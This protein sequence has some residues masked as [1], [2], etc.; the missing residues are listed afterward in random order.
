MGQKRIA[1][2]N[3][4]YYR[5]YDIDPG[6]NLSVVCFRYGHRN[7]RQIYELDV[8]KPFRNWFP[9]P[10]IIQPHV[11]DFYIPVLGGTSSG[12]S[13]RG[14]ASSEFIIVVIRDENGDV[15]AAP[16]TLK[17]IE[18]G[19]SD[20]GTAVST[21]GD[22]NIYLTNLAAGD[23]TLASKDFMLQREADAKSPVPPV[24]VKNLPMRSSKTDTSEHIVLTRSDTNVLF[25]RRMLYIVCPMC[26]DTI[27]VVKNASANLC[28]NDAFN[29]TSIETEIEVNQ[30]TFMTSRT[31]SPSSNPNS[32]IRRGSHTLDTWHGVVDVYWDESRFVSPNED[33]Y[34]LYG[35]DPVSGTEKTITII[36]RSTWGAAPVKIEIGLEY[37]D[38][39]VIAGAAGVPPVYTRSIPSNLYTQLNNDVMRWITIHHTAGDVLRGSDVLHTLQSDVQLETDP[40]KKSADIEYHFIIDQD[41]KVYEGRP[42]GIKGAHTEKF[43]GGNIGIVLAGDYQEIDLN[44]SHPDDTNNVKPTP[45]VLTVLENLVDV[46]AWRFNVKSVWWH[47]KRKKQTLGPDAFTHCPGNLLIPSL[48]SLRTR[49]PGPPL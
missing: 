7:W 27:R 23:Y 31:Q 36:G 12:V 21:D 26:G 47:Q 22:G 1:Y 43:N 9:D 37:T 10:N 2:I 35:K 3:G 20:T 8:N 29:L 28:P 33:D 17:C 15:P 32:V 13:R 6:N 18:P 16:V 45:A 24:N 44:L 5:E 42:L 38:H 19:G 34:V 11:V 46:L 25:V 41:G 39:M 49:Y 30:Q 40:I 14:K 48:A 4:K